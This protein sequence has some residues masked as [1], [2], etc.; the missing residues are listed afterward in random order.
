VTFHIS[1][2][3]IGFCCCAAEAAPVLAALPR[4]IGQFSAPPA[5]PHERDRT[6][7]I[8]ADNTNDLLILFTYDTSINCIFSAIA[9]S[10]D[11]PELSLAARKRLRRSLQIKLFHRRARMAKINV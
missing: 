7:A 8:A 3:C 2:P 6:A 1:F 5:M 10:R 4:N 11:K 9:D